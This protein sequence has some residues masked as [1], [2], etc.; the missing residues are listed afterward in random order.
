MQTYTL[1]YIEVK[2]YFRSDISFPNS[3]KRAANLL[4]V[5]IFS[6]FIGVNFHY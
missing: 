1:K 5:D 3:E 2:I 6:L 4:I